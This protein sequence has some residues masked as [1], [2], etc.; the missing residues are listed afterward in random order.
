[1][2]FH[3]QL[4]EYLNRLDCT[5]KAL[6]QSSGLSAA[7][8]SRYRAGERVPER[9]S[10]ALE[11]L[12]AAIARAAERCGKP[13]LTRE[14]VLESFL[15]CQDV[16]GTDRGLLRRNFNTLVSI[17]NINLSRLCRQINYDTSTIFRIRNGTRQPAEPEKFASGIAA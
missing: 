16:A 6:S 10:D 11:K 4:N 2:K 8:L 17:L 3:E 14:S 15:R 5:A 7:T 1:M 13:E 12:S 9:G